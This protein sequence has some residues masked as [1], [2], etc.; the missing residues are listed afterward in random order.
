VIALDGSYNIWIVGFSFIIAYFTSYQALGLTRRIR[1]S[2]GKVMWGWLLVASVVMGCGVWTMH[3]VGMMA[4]HLNITVDYQI[5]KTILSIVASVIA[6]LIAFYVS[7]SEMTQTKLFL[8][9]CFMSAGIVVMHYMGMSSM[10]NEYMVISYN[11][12][13]WTA[14]IIIAFIASYVSLRLF[15]R[16]NNTYNTKALKYIAAFMMAVAVTGMHYVGMESSSFWCIDPNYLNQAV[17]HES[18]Y[19]LL[20]TVSAVVV[21]TI[22]LTW[23][24]QYWEQSIFKKMAYTDS[25]TGLNNRH[26]MNEIFK[27]TGRNTDNIAVIFIDLDQFKFINDT[28]GHEIGDMLIQTMGARFNSFSSSSN[29]VF[30]IGGDEFMMLNYYRT[31]EEV[32]SL[33][34]NILEE[35]RKP[36]DITGHKFEITGSVGV[37][38]ANEHGVTRNSLLKAADTA[39][40][41]AK[42]RGKNQ[43]CEYNE[44]METVVIRRMEIEKGLRE[45]LIKKEFQLHYQPKWNIETNK[46]IGFEALLRYTHPTLGIITPNEFI[47][48]AEETGLII[49]IS[50]WVLQKASMDCLN[51]NRESDSQFIVSVNIS[52]KLIESKML[53]PLTLKALQFSTLEPRFLELELTEQMMIHYGQI[54]PEQVKPLTNIGVNLSMDNFGSGYTFLGSMNQ[55]PFQTIKIDRDYIENYEVPTKKAVVN[56]LIELARQLDIK[57]V[58]E[59][60]ETKP[61]MDFLKD[62][63]CSVMQGYYFKK[64]MPLKEVELWLKELAI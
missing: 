28:L 44:H 52:E 39:M 34:Q 56:S 32:S 50:E 37:S 60:V 55:M 53:A 36:F 61:Q 27:E 5:L 46:P 8:A 16:M 58:A 43:Y 15:H 47:P 35:I 2:T 3:F 57:L 14:S 13:L 49:P 38:Y 19:T 48:L 29:T 51:W 24:A 33:A 25:L 18:Q 40:Y 41:Y 9:S 11:P 22:F 12:L 54:I 1:S 30:R 62:A 4:F 42:N 20:V 17:N 6:S 7:S 21:I 64:P 10:L 31:K 45:A 23:L 26:A 59:G 63:G